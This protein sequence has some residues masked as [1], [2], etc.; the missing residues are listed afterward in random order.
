MTQNLAPL[1][2]VGFS[3]FGL[4]ATAQRLLDMIINTRLITAV[5]AHKDGKELISLTPSVFTEVC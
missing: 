2:R 3:V 5:A 1:R 4:V